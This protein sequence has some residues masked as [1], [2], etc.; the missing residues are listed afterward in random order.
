MF[1]YDN[2]RI[3]EQESKLQ[4]PAAAYEAQISTEIRN[5]LLADLVK[6][7]TS[8]V[9]KAFNSTWSVG[10]MYLDP[11]GDPFHLPMSVQ[12]PLL[13]TGSY[14]FTVEWGDDSSSHIT[15]HDQPG[16][17]HRYVAAG[18][19]AIRM[20]GVIDGLSFMLIGARTCRMITDISQWGDV[21]LGANGQQFCN[22][23]FLNITALD[24][25]KL[26]RGT[27]MYRMFYS[28][29]SLSSDFKSWETSS[30][31]SMKEMFYEAK[32]FN[33]DVSGFDTSAVTNMAGM[34]NGALAFNGDVSQW[35]TE[36]VTNMQEMFSHAKVF[37]GDVSQWNTGSVTSMRWMFCNA[38]AFNGDLRQWDTKS[39]KHKTGIF[40]GAVSFN[41]AYAPTADRV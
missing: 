30:V 39:V 35:N 3:D 2:V 7:V 14:N 26:P 16:S 41:R 15:S 32:V 20:Y 29:H 37:N 19:Y 1:V 12:L 33:G 40:L 36:L 5:H 34:F 18:T 8:Y 9:G 28:A 22:C 17:R 27:S 11:G 13:P 10:T 25:P 6:L 23:R 31:T 21:T 4:Q 24:A 38:R